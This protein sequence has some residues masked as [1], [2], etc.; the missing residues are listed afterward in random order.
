ME[1]GE[2][3]DFPGGPEVKTHA[4]NAGE[5]GFDPWSGNDP[6]PRN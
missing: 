2:R 5:S 1:N 6:W 4:P 3:G